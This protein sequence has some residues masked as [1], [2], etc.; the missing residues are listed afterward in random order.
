M[1]GPIRQWRFT[2]DPR[3][4]WFGRELAEAQDA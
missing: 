3:H 1:A 4:A 2:E